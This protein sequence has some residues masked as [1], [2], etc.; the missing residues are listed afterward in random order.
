VSDIPEKLRVLLD[1]W[2]EHNREHEE[3]FHQ[4]AGKAALFSTEV[5]QQLEEAAVGMAAASRKL[6]EARETL[7][8]S[9]EG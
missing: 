4:W 5:A 1:Y 3:E 8:K 7:A 6:E 9:K 2:I